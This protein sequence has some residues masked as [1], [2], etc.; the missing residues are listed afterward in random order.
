[1]SR[2]IFSIEFFADPGEQQRLEVRIRD[3]QVDLDALAAVIEEY[4]LLEKIEVALATPADLAYQRHER[5]H[6]S[7]VSDV[8]P[9]GPPDDLGPPESA[10]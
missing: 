9:V 8:K 1:V 2:P 7:V 6:L 5:Q 3:R 4:D 10:A